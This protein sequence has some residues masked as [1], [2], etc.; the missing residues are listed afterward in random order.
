MPQST[1]GLWKSQFYSNDV[2]YNAN[3]GDPL[4]SNRIVEEINLK[5]PNLNLLS[6]E[7]SI[8]YDDV[9]FV[10]NVVPK[11]PRVTGTLNVEFYAPL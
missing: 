8:S 9:N 11:A 2:D 4:Y 5:Y 6:E 10:N 7:V 3:P 1:P